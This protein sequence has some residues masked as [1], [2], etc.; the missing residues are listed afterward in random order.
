VGAE[1][2]VSEREVGV[3]EVGVPITLEFPDGVRLARLEELPGPESRRSADWARVQCANIAP[4]YSLAESNSPRFSGYAEINVN[5]PHIWAVFHDLCQSLLGPRATLVASEVDVEPVSLGS[6]DTCSIIAVLE[7]YKYQL[8]HDGFV[9][10]G[11]ICARDDAI[12]EVFVA[13]TKHF[14]VWL[15]NEGN[16]R[17]IMDRYGL[18]KLSKLEFIDE[19]P[20]TT[21][22]L[23]EGLGVFRP[24]DLLKCI[25]D[26]IGR[27]T[28]AKSN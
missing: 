13:P 15:N 7:R 11:L 28:G 14:K 23:P 5:A 4:G 20:R 22:A 24:S 26:S 8:S 10:F 2:C 3:G 9:Q 25:S 12:T 1:F 21:I 19:Y 6:G 27:P 16:F 18:R 17:L